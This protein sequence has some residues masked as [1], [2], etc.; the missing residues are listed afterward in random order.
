MEENKQKL[1]YHQQVILVLELSEILFERLFNTIELFFR[2]TKNIDTDISLSAFYNAIAKILQVV[3][4][5]S[6]LVTI[7]DFRLLKAD[8][9]QKSKEIIDLENKFNVGEK[10]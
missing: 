4:K 6:N 8:D 3:D 2:E 7:K 9:V 10:E 5:F 1:E